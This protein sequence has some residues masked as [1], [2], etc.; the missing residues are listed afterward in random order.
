MLKSY[1]IT[2]DT[3]RS[4]AEQWETNPGII[5]IKR[6]VQY[7]SA[8][9]KTGV[10]IFNQHPNVKLAGRIG[11][12]TKRQCRAKFGDFPEAGEAYLVEE[13]REYWQWTRIDH[14]MSLCDARGRAIK[15]A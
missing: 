3:E 12:L 5:K 10:H 14:N 7:Y 15:G 8:E 11:E 6:C 2:R 1:F 9:T 13:H 4:A